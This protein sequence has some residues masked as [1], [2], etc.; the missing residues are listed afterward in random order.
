MVSLGS[1]LFEHNLWANMRMLEVCTDLPDAILDATVQE[2]LGPSAIRSCISRA[3]SSAM[4][5]G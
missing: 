5:C 4:S 3:P 1:K 2:L